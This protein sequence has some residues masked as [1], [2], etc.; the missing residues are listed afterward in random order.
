M[1][2]LDGLGP[3]QSEGHDRSDCS[4][5]TEN[6]VVEVG[7]FQVCSREPNVERVLQ[8]LIAGS[9]AL[10]FQ[11]LDLQFSVSLVDDGLLRCGSF[12]QPLGF[13]ADA[14]GL[15]DTVCDAE[16]ETRDPESLGREVDLLGLFGRQVQE[17]D[18]VG[19]DDHVEGE[20]AKV[21]QLSSNGGVCLE[22]VLG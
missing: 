5:S 20:V 4:D 16:E 1:V 19:P 7:E 6:T 21:P 2:D 3:I 14:A 10:L 22:R 8:E 18:R 9:T 11:S 17:A 15:D 13:Q 12:A